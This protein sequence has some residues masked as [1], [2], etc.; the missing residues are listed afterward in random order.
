M[1]L[2]D[3]KQLTA[4]LLDSGASPEEAAEFVRLGGEL[5]QLA[6]T[7]V[8]H[9]ST[10]QKLAMARQIVAT[11]EKPNKWSPWLMVAG[12][13]AALI[14]GILV[15]SV[16]RSSNP[17]DL[18]YGLKRASE[19]VAVTVQPSFRDQMMMRRSEEVRHLVET[20]ADS[21]L[22]ATTIDAYI[23]DVA[24]ISSS[25]YDAVEYCTRVLQEARAK[26]GSADARSIDAGP[27]AAAEREK[28]LTS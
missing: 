26:A 1:N 5:H 25:S 28:Q 15:T 9:Q 10:A 18:A 8:A 11:S 17:G 16:A 19:Q 24:Q 13:S 6:R 27:K 21:K 23:S 7:K 12:F 20:H 3:T 14:G 22:V 2:K 4:E